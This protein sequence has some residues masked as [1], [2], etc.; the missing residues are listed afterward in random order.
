MDIYYGAAFHEFVNARKAFISPSLLDRAVK[1]GIITLC[2]AEY[3][4]G[5]LK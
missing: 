1:N 3:L 4:E 2:G 5:L